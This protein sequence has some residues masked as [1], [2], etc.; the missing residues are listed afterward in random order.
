MYFLLLLIFAISPYD[1]VSSVSLEPR[2]SLLS[3]H[4]TA[5]MD[6][7][8]NK[9]LKEELFL[10]PLLSIEFYTNPLIIQFLSHFSNY[11]FVSNLTGSSMLE[12]AALS[13]IVPVL[14]PLF[15]FSFTIFY[16]Y[17]TQHFLPH[18]T[19]HLT[20]LVEFTCLTEILFIWVSICK[21]VEC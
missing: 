21:S 9:R 3:I 11:R 15:S 17:Y 12:I 7:N 14:L 13:T 18:S 8:P 20:L 19:R 10:P 5:P 4:L 6:L 1:P 2:F 16:A